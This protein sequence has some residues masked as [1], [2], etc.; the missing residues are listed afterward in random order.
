M[1]SR[2]FTVKRNDRGPRLLYVCTF[3]DGSIFD[4]TT[5]TAV[6]F[7]MRRA[8]GTGA[9]INADAIFVDRPGAV[10]GYDPGATDF[11][12]DGEFDAEFQVSFP[13][14]ATPITFPGD[15]YIRIVVLPDIA[16]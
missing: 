2:V 13:G 14:S 5:A 3:S 7:G 9:K 1:S 4:L 8:G 6:K 12:T 15:G 10:V 11:D 16:T